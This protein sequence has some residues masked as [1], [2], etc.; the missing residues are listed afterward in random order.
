MYDLL[1]KFS[2]RQRRGK[3]Q[4]LTHSYFSCRPKKARTGPKSLHH[5]AKNNDL[6]KLLSLIGEFI[7]TIHLTSFHTRVVCESW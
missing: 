3:Q 1:T 5:A 6:D 4:I 2:Y 7:P